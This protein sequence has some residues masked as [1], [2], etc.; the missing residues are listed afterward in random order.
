MK[1]PY[2]RTAVEF[3]D[4]AAPEGDAVIAAILVFLRSENR[5]AETLVK[6]A[7]RAY[8]N[9]NI[10]LNDDVTI[11]QYRGLGNAFA[12]IITWVTQN[13]QNF[14]SHQLPRIYALSTIAFAKRGQ[15]VDD[16]LAR[17][18]EHFK[19][20]VGFDLNLNVEHVRMVYRAIG[21]FVTADNA[22]TMFTLL[23]AGTSKQSLRL[24]LLIDQASSSGLTAYL[25]I[26]NAMKE[27]H[28]FPWDRVSRLYPRDFA[29]FGEALQTVGGNLY[30][31]FN[32][33]LGVARSTRFKNLAFV[34]TKLLIKHRAEKYG[35]L[36]NYKG[37]VR[38][39]DKADLVQELLDSYAPDDFAP[40]NG[41]TSDIFKTCTNLALQ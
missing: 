3:R 9:A 36:K 35:A 23:S 4:Y 24:Q 28:D 39:P 14:N 27:F 40:M 29:A 33:D 31:R 30:Y 5:V 37:V 10:V 16:K 22:R 2:T 7:N 17:V 21:S 12:S 8:G 38:R 26:I 41:A 34:A 15:I 1:G 6:L 13:K 25:N 11:V 18:N 32:A 20:E 19:D